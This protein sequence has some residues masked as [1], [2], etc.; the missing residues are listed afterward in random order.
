M[1]SEVGSKTVRRHTGTRDLSNSPSL[2]SKGES[3]GKDK[4]LGKSSRPEME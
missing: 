3:G 2:N 1:L 4:E